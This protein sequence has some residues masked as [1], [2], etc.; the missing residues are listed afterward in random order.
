MAVPTGPQA[1]LYD[2]KKAIIY[3]MV[4]TKDVTGEPV[5]TPT[6]L[7]RRYPRF[8]SQNAGREVQGPTPLSITAMYVWFRKDSVTVT[9]NAA[10]QII[11]RG[12]TYGI[13]S[14]NPIDYGTGEVCFLVQS[15]NPVT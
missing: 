6:E 3:Q 4:T 10:M 15:V 5:S 11:H 1:G 2:C 13:L 9:I 12:V 8:R 7:C 14:P